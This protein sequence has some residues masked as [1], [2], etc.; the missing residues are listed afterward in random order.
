V[1]AAAFFYS[2][3]WLMDAGV[4]SSLLLLGFYALILWRAACVVVQVLLWL[5]ILM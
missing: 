1:F 2:R 5:Y 3:H 4:T